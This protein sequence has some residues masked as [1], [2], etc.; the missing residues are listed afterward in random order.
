MIVVT[1]AAGF[2]AS[3]LVARLNAEGYLDIVVVDDFSRKDKLNNLEG[4]HITR[5]VHRDDFMSWLDDH[6]RM[7]QFV[8]H[9]GARTDTAEFSH[10]VLDYLNFDYSV[11]VWN[12]CIK[13]G[14]PLVYASSAATYGMGEQGFMDEESLIPALKPLNPYGESKNEF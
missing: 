14:L 8:Y 7:V 2:I 4:K 1:G 10:Q 3:C 6:H 5:H 9:L 13:Y 11:R 12:S